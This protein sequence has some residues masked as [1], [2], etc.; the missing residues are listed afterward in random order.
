VISG[1]DSLASLRLSSNHAIV[2][3]VAQRT[4]SPSNE[5]YLRNFGSRSERHGGP[6]KSF[7]QA[8]FW[9]K[10]DMMLGNYLILAGVLAR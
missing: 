3:L 6:G 5:R 9:K 1:E 4:I 7:G 10:V 2:G 8:L